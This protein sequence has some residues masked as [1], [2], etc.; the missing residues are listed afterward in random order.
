MADLG[1]LEGFDLRGR[2]FA[3]AGL[4]EGTSVCSNGTGRTLMKFLMGLIGLLCMAALPVEALAQERTGRARN[5]PLQE[6]LKPLDVFTTQSSTL[7]F[8]GN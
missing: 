2:W 1:G 6:Q 3:R 8:V 4:A 7:I 5:Q